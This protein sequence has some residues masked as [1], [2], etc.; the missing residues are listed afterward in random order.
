MRLQILLP[1]FMQET[2]QALFTRQKKT[3]LELRTEQ[4]AKRKER[5]HA[6]KNWILSNRS[7][8][9]NAMMADLSKPPLETDATE[10]F[11]VLNEI[12][13]ALGDLDRW[14][15]PKK[16]DAP[17]EMMGTTAYIQYEPRG[18]CLI[19][20]PWNYPFS[21]SISPLVSA[22]AAGNT[23]ILKPSELSPAISAEISRM[24]KE[25]FDPS[26]VTVVEGEAEMSKRLLT[27]PFDHIFFTGSPS[28]GKQVM[29]AAA[30]NLSSVTLE[31]GGKSPAIVTASSNLKDAAHRIAVTKF[32]NNGQTCVAPDYVLVDKKIAGKF[33]DELITR[34][35]SSFDA[36]DNEFEKSPHY[37]RIVNEKHHARL[38]GLLDDA[39]KSG[40]VA[41][42]SGVPDRNKKFMPPV[43]LTN[44][45]LQSR[46]MEEEIFGPI[47]PVITY[48]KIDDALAIIQAKPK[49][50]SLY[51]FSNNRKET[52]KL[53]K[54]TSAG[55]VCINDCGIQFLNGNIPFGGVNNSG[56]GQSHGYYGFLNFSHEKPVL[57][58]SNIFS[59]FSIF[60]PPY[61]KRA[62]LLMN[63]FL[64]LFYGGSH[65]PE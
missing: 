56:M 9:H 28:I 25:V 59:T 50:L 15:K 61:T 44:V 65:K 37:S 42:L 5:L 12:K 55:G 26:V 34:I 43:V 14:T 23:A 18:T 24:A 30:E 11:L 19:I 46:V 16:I 38:N 3:S 17:L 47:L 33:T 49:P 40:A 36:T 64:K 62:Q 63:W 21:L 10:I 51:I 20:S 29:K 48:E 41:P 35:K 7:A 6:L 32:I 27:L 8:L 57:R 52:D 58:Q 53:L 2:L 45:S 22:L 4:I 54:L 1:C 39:L 60:Y 31:L 13:H